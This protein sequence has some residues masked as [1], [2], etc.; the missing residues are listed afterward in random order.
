MKNRL[1]YEVLPLIKEY[2]VEGLL[3]S[4]KDEFS[5]FFHQSIQEELYR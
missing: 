3:A 4:G 2:L 1:R 5:A